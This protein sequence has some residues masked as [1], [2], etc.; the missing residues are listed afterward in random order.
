MRKLL[1]ALGLTLGLV[2]GSLVADVAPAS[3]SIHVGQDPYGSGCAAGAYMAN[4]TTVYKPGTT[5]AMFTVENW[6][7][8]ACVTNWAVMSWPHSNMASFVD[9]HTSGWSQPGPSNHRQCYRTNCADTYNGQAQPMWTNMIEG[10]DVACI[11]AYFQDPA[12]RRN[13]LHY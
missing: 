13:H 6:Y 5:R 3:A 7:S 2:L 8:P 11:F 9:I 4:S 10:Q 12:Y 1:W